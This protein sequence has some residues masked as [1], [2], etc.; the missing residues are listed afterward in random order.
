MRQRPARARRH[1]LVVLALTT[2][3]GCAGLTGCG[4]DTDSDSGD[5]RTLTTVRGKVHDVPTKPKRVV[6][7]D[8]AELDSALT[9]GVKPV[10]ATKSDVGS[11]FLRYLPEDKV[12]GIADVGNIGAPNLEKIAKLKP[13][14]ILS[15][16]VRDQK[17]YDELSKIAPTVFTKTTGY[18]WKANFLVHA[19]ALGRKAEARK[20][21]ADYRDH[22]REVTRSLGGAKKAGATEVG[23]LRFTEGA[24]SRIYGLRSYIA[25]LLKDVGLGRPPIAAKAT[26]YDGLGMDISPEQVDKADA[27]VLF[28]STYGD[29]RK[30]GESKT[31]GSPL[32]KNMNAVKKDRAFRVEDELWIQGIGYTAAEQILDEL[33]KRLTQ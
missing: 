30:A 24:D 23:V 8:T 21:I 7:L 33:E 1:S 22:T 17:R 4:S 28:W 32:W 3:L 29:P 20:V 10:G 25:T 15:S 12:R 19:E 14:L 31:V 16:D 11:G 26:D 13:D 9:L 2:S 6:V 27:D 18:P 5:G